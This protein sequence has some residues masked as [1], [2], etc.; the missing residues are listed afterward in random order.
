V[1]IGLFE[2]IETIGKTLALNLNNL[3]D[4]FGLGKKIVTFVKDEGANLNAMSLALNSI[5]KVVIWKKVSME[6]V[7]D[8]FLP[9]HANMGLL[10][11]K[12]AKT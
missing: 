11:R 8:M 2:V 3:L 4:S 12:F 5:V 1:T 7:F 6:V 10:R 9:R